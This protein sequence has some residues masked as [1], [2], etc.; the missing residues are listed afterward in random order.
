MSVP[1]LTSHQFQ[2]IPY[3]QHG[4]FGRMGG[5]SQG[6]FDSLNTGLGNGDIDQHVLENR[7]RVSSQFGLKKENLVI[8]RQEHTDTVY[9]VHDLDLFKKSAPIGD[10]MVTDSPGFLL[11]IRTA[12]CV[13]ILFA[14]KTKPVIGAAHAGWRG[15]HGGIIE[16]TIKAMV[17]LG[18]H[19]DNII[20]ALGPCIW[21]DYYEV[22][23]EFMDTL[24]TAPQFF[25]PGR[26]NEHFQFDLPGYVEHRLRE[27]GI[28]SISS[29]PVDT[30]SNSQRFFSYRR[31]TKN[32][33]ECVGNQVS[34]ISIK[35]A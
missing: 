3:I 5:V 21:Q 28:L 18:S 26:D 6:L 12:D 9:K 33:E 16:S 25:K 1:Y 15:A 31:K 34:V 23:L 20:A 27:A 13:P 10:G 30:Y 35:N 4:F 2:S 29:S 19:P 7:N 24:K 17:D 14:D 32:R 8:L 11:G 22:T